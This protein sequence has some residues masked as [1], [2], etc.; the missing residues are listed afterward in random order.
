M[1]FYAHSLPDKPEDQWQPLSA[2]LANVAEL[3][4]Q[5]AA[6]FNAE[7]WARA[8]GLLHDLGKYTL[9]FQERLRGAKPVDHS[10]AGAQWAVANLD[11]PEAPIGKLLAYAIAGHHGG[12]PDG[13]AEGAGSLEAR[14]TK[15]LAGLDGGPADPLQGVSLSNPPIKLEKHGAQLSFFLRM[16]FSCLVDADYLDTEAFMDPDRA[17]WR[18]GRPA[19]AELWPRLEAYLDGLRGKVKDGPLNRRRN[20][21]LEACLQ[22]AEMPPGFFSLT[23]PTGGGKTISSLAF[24]LKHALGHGLRRVIYVIPYTSI[25]EQNAAVFK[26]ILGDDAVLEHHSNLPMPEPGREED[27]P[28][29][30]RNRLAS[31]NWDSPVVVTTNVQFFESLFA[32]RTSRCRKLHNMVKSAIILDEAQMLPRETLIPCLEALRELAGNYGCSV[33][34]CTATQPVLSDADTFKKAAVHP[35]EIAP[36][37]AGLYQ[38]FRRV[39]VS[40]HDGQ[41]GNDELARHLAAEER[42]LCIVNTRAQAR[43]LF[44][45]LRGLAGPQGIFHLSALMYPGHRARKLKQIKEALE[46]E[47][48]CRVVSTQLVEAGVDLNFPVVWRAL[49]GV[50]S[51]AQAAG[52][53]NRE[54]KLPG[55]G[56]LHVFE[57]QGKI[58]DSQ[59][60]AAQKAR[61]VLRRFPDPLSLEAVRQYF[62]HL[63]WQEKDKLDGKG[64]MTLLEAGVSKL[65]LPFATVAG[66][67]SY[68]DSPGE[69]VLV[70]PE[71]EKREAIIAGLR[72]SPHPGRFA[73]Q[74]QPYTVQLYPHELRGLVQSHDVELIGEGL[75]PVLVNQELYDD[76]LGLL[77][78]RAG[79][80]GSPQGLYA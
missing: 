39:E 4:A 25:I 2:H 27:D 59:K 37:P 72:Y 18:E 33:V 80:G 9:P 64:I 77:V 35:R 48:V 75:F 3:A 41:L 8:A 31:E 68:F 14:L 38:E 67:F 56:R 49:A 12:L 21:I 70:C 17:R 63:F 19:L 60:V 26:T 52:R 54:G 69:A 51:L 58:R 62:E 43:E 57:P 44:L 22:A 20:Q 61:G 16:V 15:R 45:E 34:L 7:D 79:E 36:D 71:I 53:C 42:V 40:K 78:E 11:V 23:V 10:T 13:V 29:W 66:L 74:A 5:R 24:A 30:Q 47:G 76:D 46:R 65:H 73:R 32:N 6:Y 28:A 50:D 1:D 55:M